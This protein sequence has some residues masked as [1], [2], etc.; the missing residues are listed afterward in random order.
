MHHATLRGFVDEI[1]GTLMKEA[2]F[3][4]WVAKNKE[5]LTH[6][7]EVAGLGI[8]AAPTIGK[9]MSKNKTMTPEQKAKQEKRHAGYELG[10]LGILAA[11]SAIHLAH[12]A[13]NTFRR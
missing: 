6:G 11:P 10:G 9:M 7:A 13:Y 5:P 4:S 12:G 8:L 2:G 3:G 1:Q